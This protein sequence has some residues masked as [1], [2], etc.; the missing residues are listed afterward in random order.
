MFNYIKL[1]S[2]TIPFRNSYLLKRELFKTSEVLKLVEEAEN[3]FSSCDFPDKIPFLKIYNKF[4]AY[5]YI[6]RTISLR[7]HSLFFF[8]KIYEDITKEQHC[9]ELR[10]LTNGHLQ[11]FSKIELA[12]DKLLALHLN[13][14]RIKKDK[15]KTELDN[16]RDI[17]HKSMKKLKLL[18]GEFKKD[19]L[20][21][22]M[23]GDNLAIYDY[24]THDTYS[25]I[26]KIND[27]R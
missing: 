12:T 6:D 20:I 23:D 1:S 9:N 8:L 21:I 4:K 24:H 7:M 15:R 27:K 11:K 22:D 26:E 16:R 10:M 18:I 2:H 13:A 5:R 19:N 25:I 14:E 3:L 17:I